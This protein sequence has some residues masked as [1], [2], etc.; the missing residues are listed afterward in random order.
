MAICSTAAYAQPWKDVPTCG[1][2]PVKAL[3][4]HYLGTA[5]AWA[6]GFFF[7]DFSSSAE[8]GA[9]AV[10]PATVTVSPTFYPADANFYGVIFDSPQFSVG[11]GQ[12]QRTR[13]VVYINQLAKYKQTFPQYLLNGMDDIASTTTK[14]GTVD[15][16]YQFYDAQCNSIPGANAIDYINSLGAVY[17]QDFTQ[18]FPQGALLPFKVV[19]DVTL[20]GNKGT[21]Q[22]HNLRLAVFPGGP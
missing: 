7:D 21:A 13:F 1:G 12:T 3:A 9:V 11:S 18:Q 16:H 4:P 6:W 20:R 8:G 17:E 2:Q 19:L 22:V 5:C 15:L 14:D 10:D